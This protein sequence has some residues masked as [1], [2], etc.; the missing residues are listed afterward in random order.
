MQLADAWLHKM[1]A[2]F[3]AFEASASDAWIDEAP[4][5]YIENPCIEALWRRNHDELKLGMNQL[6]AIRPS[7]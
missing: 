2:Y 7:A 4:V 6:R 1:Q 5:M 3:D